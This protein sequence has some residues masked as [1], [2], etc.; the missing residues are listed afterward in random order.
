MEFSLSFIGTCSRFW[1]RMVKLQRVAVSD[2]RNRT[3]RAGVP[4]R[5]TGR[6]TR[7]WKTN[8][9]RQC[10]KWS[11]AAGSIIPFPLPVQFGTCC[12]M[13]VEKRIYFEFKDWYKK[14]TWNLMFSLLSN[15]CFA[16]ITYYNADA[17]GS[18]YL[19]L[20]YKRIQHYTFPSKNIFIFSICS[21]PLYMC[22]LVSIDS[23]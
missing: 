16:I 3:D 11:Q 7:P 13:L 17:F 2:G 9:R 4:V 8:T 10:S 14:K 6:M 19:M 21:G 15:W 23:L 5:D 22:F 1:G 18:F 12:L 20:S